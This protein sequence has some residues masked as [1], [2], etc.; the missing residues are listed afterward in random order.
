MEQQSELIENT[1]WVEL[2]PIKNHL[3]NPS[4]LK[5]LQN[6]LLTF[7]G[8]VNSN[9]VRNYILGPFEGIK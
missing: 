5:E 7:V 8:C 3:S 9:I 2:Y 1:G 6:E 4:F